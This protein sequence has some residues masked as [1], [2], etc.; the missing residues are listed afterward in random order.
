MDIKPNI[1]PFKFV[2]QIFWLTQNAILFFIVDYIKVIR[3]PY[4]TIIINRVLIL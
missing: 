4:S 2:W 3:R 1:G